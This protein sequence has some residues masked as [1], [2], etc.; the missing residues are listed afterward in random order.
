MIIMK[1]ETIL[2]ALPYEAPQL[3]VRDCRTELSFLL[4]NPSGSIPGLE[5]VDNGDPWS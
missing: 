4:S 2:A 5:E 1:K 3:R